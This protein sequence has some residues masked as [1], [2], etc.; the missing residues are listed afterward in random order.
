MILFHLF[1][2]LCTHD[3][4]IIKHRKKTNERKMNI[5]NTGQ[6]YKNRQL[7][8]WDLFDGVVRF[9]RFQFQVSEDENLLK[10]TLS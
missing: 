10:V 1:S 2:S 5:Y 3:T 6:N 7:F 9:L 4:L 8:Q